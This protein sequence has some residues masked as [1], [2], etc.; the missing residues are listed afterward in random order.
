[1][2]RRRWQIVANLTAL[3]YFLISST[4]HHHHHRGVSPHAMAQCLFNVTWLG[5]GGCELGCSPYSRDLNMPKNP[6]SFILIVF[7]PCFLLYLPTRP[8]WSQLIIHHLQ[9][10]CTWIRGTKVSYEPVPWSAKINIFTTIKT[11]KNNLPLPTQINGG[12]SEWVDWV[13]KQELVNFSPLVLL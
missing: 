5:I 9:T 8:W 3:N 7:A 10:R 4:T 11:T 2:G 6:K 1:M 13:R 12:G